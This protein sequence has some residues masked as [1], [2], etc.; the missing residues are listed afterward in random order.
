MALF[1][2]DLLLR[3]RINDMYRRIGSFFDKVGRCVLGVVFVYGS[4]Q[5]I[6]TRYVFRLGAVREDGSAIRL[7][8]CCVGLW[9]CTV[10]I[11]FGVVYVF[12]LF[13]QVC[14]GKLKRDCRVFSKSS[15][16][17]MNENTED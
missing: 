2:V 5:L 12:V 3:F 8:V 13:K 10:I 9:I 4:I 16:F 1:G 17:T 14:N 15:L 7:A 11:S 6:L